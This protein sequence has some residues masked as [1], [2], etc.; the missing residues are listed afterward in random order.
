MASY[1]LQAEL[2]RQT[3]SPQQ[4][5]MRRIAMSCPPSAPSECVGRSPG[6]YGWENLYVSVVLESGRCSG[7][8]EGRSDNWRAE[9]KREARAAIAAT[10]SAHHDHR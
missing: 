8:S 9:R 6:L 3:T 2:L 4:F 5:A 7:C 1:R 10:S